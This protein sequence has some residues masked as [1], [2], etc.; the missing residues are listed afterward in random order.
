MNESGSLY[1][2]IALW[3]Q[4]VSAILFLVVLLW[5]W[6]KFI[7]PAILAAQVRYN[8]HIAEA[9]RHR[10]EAKA[11]LDMLQNEITGA[12]RDA[13]LI[14]QRATTQAQREYDAAVAEAREAGERSLANA[15][16]EFGRAVAAARDRLR[17]EMLEKALDRARREASRRLTPEANAK[18]VDGFVASL[19]RN[20]G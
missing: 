14:R 12:G 4:V 16:A 6:V 15:Q 7:Q 17:V 8:K 10:D 5:L 20:R 1:V 18:L 13:D 19:E 3:S 9:E 11:T 2:Q